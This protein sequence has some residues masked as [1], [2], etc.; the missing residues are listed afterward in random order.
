MNDPTQP[1]AQ[2]TPMSPDMHR[3]MREIF[4]AAMERPES[5]R[6]LYVDASCGGDQDLLQAVVRL[7]S[8]QTNSQGFLNQNQN[9]PQRIGRY[10]IVGELGRG[11]MGVVYE[12]LDPLI[13][14]KVAVKVILLE[15]L[16]TGREATFLRDRL[17]REAHS[18][19]VLSHPGIV[20][21]YDVGEENGTAFIAM[22]RVEGPSLFQVL[23]SGKKVSPQDA[24]EILR[25]TASALDYAHRNQIVHRD[26]KPANIMIDKGRTVK[27]ADF[28]IAKIQSTQAYTRTGMIM[29][30]PS[31]MSPEQI[32]AKPLDG[33]SDQ[34]S[35]AVIAYE[36]FTGVKPFE[37]D[38]LATLVHMIVYSER[39]SA[40][41]FNSSLP[42]GIDAVLRRGLAPAAADRYA[43]CGEFVEAL[44]AAL[45]GEVAVPA[46]QPITQQPQPAATPAPQPATRKITPVDE[47]APPPPTP[48]T[49]TPSMPPP[50]P[51]PVTHERS[52]VIPL[53]I[54]VIFCA[55]LMGGAYYYFFVMPGK[56]I[57]T[58]T[59]T[60]TDRPA[61]K[62]VT[63]P[64]TQPVTKE[65]PKTPP[66]TPVEPTTT[67]PSTN[68]SNT[69]STAPPKAGPEPPKTPDKS[70]RI[71]Q[72]FDEATAKKTA[73]QPA[74][75]VA[76][77]KQAADLG[78]ARSMNE[79]G[80]LYSTDA[81]GF[82]EKDDE[83]VKWF[84]KAADLGNVPGM[85]NLGTAYA[86]G[87]GVTADDSRAVFWYRKAADTGSAAGMFDLGT[88]YESG[89]GVPKDTAKAIEYYQK[90]ADSGHTEAK[91]RLSKLKR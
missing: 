10:M 29:G 68:P 82:P 25:Q 56:T 57:T 72:L 39:P 31:Y 17:F 85:L 70:V 63:Q 43:T 78:D 73:G 77:L 91:A 27:V 22:E 74:A 38:S 52:A 6:L 32:E 58:T 60:A 19:G 2:P 87:T 83:A 67:A 15:S 62:A 55:G 75:A 46:K 45:R 86:L 26:I 9:Q 66:V 35:L 44:E 76:L 48:G 79:I 49:A 36:L 88:M 4:D 24:L 71:K 80:E 90:A 37:S 61:T 20:V 54:A 40:L 50:P 59:T 34:F 30:T 69:S 65:P 51:P 41:K 5:E 33:R 21:V 28:G 42:P 47:P 14:R 18:A 12:G 11:A 1:S 7:L 81:P 64:V 16:G 89:R 13:R 23:D 3:R 8:A 53:L 84:R